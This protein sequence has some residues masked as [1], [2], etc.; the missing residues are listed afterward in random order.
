M[1][2]NTRAQDLLSERKEMA[3][4]TLTWDE[5]AEQAWQL[6]EAGRFAESLALITPHKALFPGRAL[7]YQAQLRCAAHISAAQAA[8]VM[9]TALADGYWF[10][11]GSLQR[12]PALAPLL[13]TPAFAPLL[14]L[15]RARRTQ[16]QAEAAPMLLTMQPPAA[17]PPYP[18]FLALHGGGGSLA[19]SV[20]VWRP[21]VQQGWLLALPQSSQVGDADGYT[22]ND[23]ARASAE[24]L[25]HAA[26]VAAGYPLAAGRFV[27]GGFSMGAG[28]AI[29][30]ATSKALAV[31]GFLAVA[32]FTPDANRLIEQVKAHQPHTLRGYLAVGAEDHGLA[33]ARALAEQLPAHGIPCAIEVHPNTGHWFPPDFTASLQRGLAFILQ[34]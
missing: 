30:L 32:P 29:Q 14:A 26:A 10:D 21:L 17:P 12:E 34:T 19:A 23:P 2:I 28:L 6:E 4:S 13:A 24:I 11:E 33:T 8:D 15:S 5:L 9:R 16:A 1:V 18:A 25:A 31:C 27:V 20:A 7:Y 3:M 22:W